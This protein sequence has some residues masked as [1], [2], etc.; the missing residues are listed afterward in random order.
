MKPAY[1]EII[2]DALILFPRLLKAGCQVLLGQIFF[3]PDAQLQKFTSVHWLARKLDVE[4]RLIDHASIEEVHSGTATRSRLKIQYSAYE[5]PAP[6][7]DSLFIKSRAPDFG[8]VLF[9]I[10]FDLGGNEV[11]FYQRIRSDLPIKSPQ[12]FHSEGDS[13]NYAI[14]MEDLTYKDCHFRD[15]ASECSIEEAKSII[16]ALARLHAEFWQ[17]ERFETD[18]A[19]V[20]CFET[21]RDFRLL[22]LVRQLSVPIAYKKYAH[23]LPRSVREVIPHLM[24]NYRRLEEQWAE[25]PRT[26]LHGDAH[27]GNM[28][29]QDGQVGFLDWQ[30]N[31]RGQGM[32]DVAYFLI[33]SMDTEFRL[34]HQEVL[35]RHY[36]STLIECGIVFDF[37][38]AWR[39]YRLQSVY[40]WVA[41]IVTAP[42]NFQPERVVISGL[43]R[44]CRA[45][46]DLNAIDL[47]REL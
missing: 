25:E 39:Q 14:L 3:R 28:Y 4:P 17:S 46:V 36:L 18:L 6:G 21:N 45:I 7:P 8:S 15:L 47:I 44:S 34:A 23:V 42:S 27:L 30:V 33:N 12:I 11:A 38:L 29:F 10:L 16:S 41:G 35:I 20:N 31:Q 22:N 24:N 26:L 2:R 40:A 9:G 13:K 19:W 1:F 43:S 37:D 32:R 5:G